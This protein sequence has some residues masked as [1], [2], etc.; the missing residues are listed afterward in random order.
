MSA[1]ARAHDRVGVAM[2]DGG[3]KSR[4]GERG[5]SGHDGGVPSTAEGLPAAL[6]T[7]ALDDLPDGIAIHRSI[8]DGAG[9]IVDF[10]VEYANR[11]L[12]GLTGLSVDELVGHTIL[13]LF[14][15]RREN[16]VFEGY[17]RVVETGESMLRV[18][19]TDGPSAGASDP[20]GFG[21]NFDLRVSKL[22]DGYLA[23]MRDISARSQVED[24]LFRSQEML[25]L[26]LDTIP[27]RV[28]WK[29]L[30]SRFLGGNAAFARDVGLA[31]SE[32]EG[33]TDADLGGPETADRYRAEDGWIVRSGESMLMQEDR[34]ARPGGGF[35]WIRASKV[36]LR[37]RSGAIVG[38]LGTF[39]DITEAKLSEQAVRDSE[40]LLD[41]VL[42][43]IPAMIFVK[44]ARD[45]RFVRVNR[46]QAELV[47][48]SRQDIEA[49]DSRQDATPA[50]VEFFELVDRQVLQTGR[51]V[52]IPEE[53]LTTRFEDR[54]SSHG[55]DPDHERAGPAAISTGDLGRHHRA[56][57]NRA[58]APRQRGEV[59]PHHRVHHG[60][61]GPRGHR[62]RPRGQR[63]SRTGF[64]CADRLFAC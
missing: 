52:D 48:Y 29:D 62:E 14:P 33:K 4:R 45:L 12:A 9:R 34:V 8:R 20:E 2:S 32:I 50:E 22:G 19:R 26:V 13:E 24:E 3:A 63:G 59:P 61:H 23:L 5:G 57:G 15:G 1:A 40:Q 53:R 27:Q 38:I 7:E 18:S 58:G 39:E 43:N 11:A 6:L 35:G 60:L 44:D 49:S 28:F 21:R 54:D 37:D 55:Q 56:Q 10:R 30:D 31:G 42:D 41:T 25:R 16:G 46:A 51:V 64:G 36:P 17:V 47:G